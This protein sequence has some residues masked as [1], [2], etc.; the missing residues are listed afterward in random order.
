MGR[1]SSL[2]AWLQWLLKISLSVVKRIEPDGY[3]PGKY[4]FTLDV[5]CSNKKVIY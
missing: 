4:R 3:R 5:I 1:V 2:A